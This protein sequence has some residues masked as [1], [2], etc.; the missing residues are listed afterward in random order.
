M[1]LRTLSHF[2]NSGNVEVK[3]FRREELLIPESL[4]SD[5]DIKASTANTAGSMRPPVRFRAIDPSPMLPRKNPSTSTFHEHDHSWHL[6]GS[7]FQLKLE[8]RRF[9]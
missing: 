4:S 2:Q 5:K 9:D 6:A 3:R 7:L 8:I 1:P